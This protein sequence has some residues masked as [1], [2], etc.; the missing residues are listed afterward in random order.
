MFDAVLFD[1]DGTLLDS[2]DLILASYR[3]TLAE[4]GLP[5]HSDEDVLSGLGTTLEAQFRRWGY[6]ARLDAL[7]ASYVAHNLAVHDALVRPYPGVNDVVRALHADGVPLGLVTSKRRRGGEQGLRALGLEGLFAV[8]IYGD[9]V[10]SPKPDPDPVRRALAGLGLP[11]S[12]RVTFVGDAVHD[13]DAGRAAGIHTIGVTWGAGRREELAQADAL[14][15]DA[16]GL[17]RL[18][19]PG[20]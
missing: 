12:R 13:V 2:I 1:L 20:S 15:D 11:A 4:H 3:H 18:L 8:E 17:A 6:E 7:V 16:A 5:P 9:E 14:V 10:T 19:R